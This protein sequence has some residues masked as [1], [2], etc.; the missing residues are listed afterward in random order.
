VVR[1]R[2]MWEGLRGL[3]A[4]D[5]DAMCHGDLTPQ[6]VLVDAGHLAGVLDTG[7]F[8]AADPAL[9]LVSVWHLLDHER[10]PKLGW[11]ALRRA[12]QPVLVIADRPPSLVT[13]DEHLHIDMPA[14]PMRVWDAIQRAAPAPRRGAEKFQSS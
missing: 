10:R 7:G 1:L 8:G 12:C 4:I 9:D 13:P 5:R 11:E 14:H 2:A 6:N 3:P